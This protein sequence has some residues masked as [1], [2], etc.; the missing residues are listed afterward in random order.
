MLSPYIKLSSHFLTRL[1]VSPAICFL[2]DILVTC[3]VMSLLPPLW[4]SPRAWPGLVSLHLMALSCYS[5]VT[6][7]LI[8]H[9]SAIPILPHIHKFPQH[10]T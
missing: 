6:S 3:L 8:T 9:K 10:I 7:M 5:T 1:G 2:V 4:K